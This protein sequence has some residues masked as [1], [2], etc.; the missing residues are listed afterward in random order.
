MKNSNILKACAA[1]GQKPVC[2]YPTS[3][4]NDGKCE[5]VKSYNYHFSYP[6]HNDQY[7]VPRGKVVGAYFYAGR[8]NGDWSFLNMG[9]T[10][11]WSGTKDINGDTFCVKKVSGLQVQ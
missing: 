2:D 10:H 5:K 11:R 3:S 9:Y 7:G 1:I 6:P 4:Y 8:A